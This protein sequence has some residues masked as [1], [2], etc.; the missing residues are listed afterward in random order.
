MSNL[1]SVVKALRN[2]KEE[3]QR[4]VKQLDEALKALGVVGGFGKAPERIGRAQTTDATRKP[5]SAAA[6][7]RIADAQRVRWAKWK[8]A[9]K[10]K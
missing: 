4:R 5:M 7:R 8:A 2:E 6:R 10:A 3:A 9:R 1:A